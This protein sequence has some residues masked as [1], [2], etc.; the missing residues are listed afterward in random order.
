M[1]PNHP[2]PRSFTALRESGYFVSTVGAGD[3]LVLDA[4]RHGYLN[5]GHAHA[6]ALSV[7]VTTGSRPLLI[8]PGTATYTMDAGLRDRFRSS[9]MHNTVVL[10][11]QS[12]SVPDGPFHWARSASATAPI[13]RG[14]A[15][16]DYVE[17]THDGYLPRRHTRGV[18]GIHGMGWWILDHVVG[19]ERAHA[20][21][22]W[23][24]HPAWVV[25]G[26]Y[27]CGVTLRDGRDT[28]AVASS[29]R[30]TVLPPGRHDLAV[31]S[32]AYGVVEPAPVLYATAD[33]DLPATI[34]TFI[35]TRGAANGMV[36]ERL[37]VV[38][39]PPGPW[40][41]AAFRAK[42]RGGRMTVLAAI[43]RTGVASGPAASP[44]SRWGTA[45]LSTDARIAVVLEQNGGVEAM[46]VNGRSLEPTVPGP[47]ILDLPESAPI[48]RIRMTALAPATLNL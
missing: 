46:L 27:A 30:L 26:E 18:L 32:T 3:Q 39:P 28:A 1:R 13:W 23:H 15:G 7:V 47:P 19:R 11:H 36:I 25:A 34:A 12:Q 9:A 43:E 2:A 44:P 33:V 22:Y 8:D 42:W 4:G 29:E 40:H 38:Q 37:P 21:V 24:L 35:D 45:D 20:D 14:A 17:A 5:G 6:D 16:C 31:Y 48:A 10:D 41:A